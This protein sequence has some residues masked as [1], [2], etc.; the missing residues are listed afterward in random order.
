MEI[1]GEH[2]QRLAKAADAGEGLAG[3]LDV[4]VSLD[5][6]FDFLAGGGFGLRKS[7][8][9]FALLMGLGG[10]PFDGCGKLLVQRI[11]GGAGLAEGGVSFEDAKYDGCGGKVAAS[12]GTAEGKDRGDMVRRVVVFAATGKGQ[13]Y[14]GGLAQLRDSKAGGGYAGVDQ[15]QVIVD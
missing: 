6:A 4:G 14:D 1:S 11:E 13:A 2:V 3:F 7:G 12:V 8:G 5:L 10:F 9:C 15:A